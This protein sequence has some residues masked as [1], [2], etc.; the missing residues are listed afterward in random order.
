MTLDQLSIDSW[1]EI[2]TINEQAPLKKR[3]QD[4][5]FVCGA[6]VQ[7]LQKSFAGDPIAYFIRGSVIALRQEDC[8]Y[9]TVTPLN[10]ERDNHHD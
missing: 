4:L 9:I 6:K 7:C 10:K 5:G 3:L 2:Q 8:R 1:A